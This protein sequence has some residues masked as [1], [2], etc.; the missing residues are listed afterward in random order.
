MNKGTNILDISG[1]S[2]QVKVGVGEAC[3]SQSDSLVGSVED[4]V[5]SFKGSHANN[6][7][8]TPTYGANVIYNQ[9]NLTGNTTHGSVKALRQYLGVRSEC[10]VN[11]IK[12][13]KRD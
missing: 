13:R 8:Q 11:L 12:K 4:T 7:G 10:E 9:V 1:I 2:V 5:E 6:E 3:V